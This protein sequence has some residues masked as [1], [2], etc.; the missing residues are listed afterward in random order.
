[1]IRRD[2]GVRCVAAVVRNGCCIGMMKPART[3]RGTIPVAAEKNMNENNRGRER[4][5][6]HAEQ[7]DSSSDRLPMKS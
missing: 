7:E 1:M 4:A 2:R 5:N 3:S 6:R